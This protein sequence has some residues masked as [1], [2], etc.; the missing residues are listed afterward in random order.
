MVTTPGKKQVP[1]HIRDNIRALR[2]EDPFEGA[3][4]DDLHEDPFP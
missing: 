1:Q 2:D 3:N 4:F